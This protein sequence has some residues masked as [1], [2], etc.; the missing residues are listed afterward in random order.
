[1]ADAFLVGERPIARRVD[2]SVVRVRPARPR[3][4]SGARRGYAP[5]AV[6][7]AAGRTPGARLGADLKNT[8][9]LVVDG[10]AFVSQHIG[11]LEHYT[12]LPR[13]RGDDRT[14]CWRCTRCGRDEL[15]VVHDAHPQY[16]STAFAGTLGDAERRRRAAP[17]RP[18]RLGAGR[19]RRVGPPRARREP[20][21]HRL[22]R[23][24]H[25]L[26]RRALRRA[27]CATAS[28]AWPTSAPAALAGGDAAAR[29]PVQAAAGFLDAARRAARPRPPRRSTFPARYRAVAP[30]ARERHAR[31]RDHLGGPPVRHR[32]GAAGLHPADHVRGPGRDVAR[33]ARS[34]GA[35]RRAVSLPVRRRLS[36]TCD[37]CCAPSSTDRLRGRDR[38]EIARAFHAGWPRGLCDAAAALCRTHGLDTVVASGGVFQNELLLD[39]S[40][41]LLERGGLDA[42]D[43]PRGPAQRRRHQPGTGRARRARTMHELS[44]ALSLVD[45]AQEEAGRQGGRVCAL[46]LRLGALAGVVPEALLASYEMAC[47]ET[48]LEGSRLVIEEVPVVVFCPRCQAQRPLEQRAVVLLPRVRHAHAAGR[49]RPGAG[50]GRPGDRAMSHEPRLVEVRKNIL[51]QNDL[52]AREL[53]QRFRDAGVF[54]VSLVSSPGAG[55][56]TL[57]ERTLTLLHA[58]TPRRRAGGRSGHRERRGPPGA[59]RRAGPADHH[60]HGLPPRG[61]DGADARW[62]AGRSTSSTSCSS[63]TSATWCARRRTTWARACASS[64]CPSPRARTS[65][66]STP[67]S[68]TP[69]TSRSSPRSTW[70][71][72]VGFDWDRGAGQHPGRAAWHADARRLGEDRR[73]DDRAPG[74]ARGGPCCAAAA[75]G[76]GRS[77]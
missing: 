61:R 21:R 41:L 58:A 37:R 56:T 70:P 63:R 50:A 14:T 36:S 17:S 25:D 42:L 31:V 73:G 7:A 2:D 64:C 72:P 18:R 53:R 5:G 12:A 60:R 74:A 34:Q 68:S 28:S 15:L 62:R 59:Q 11:D 40:P 66:S 22:R 57:L 47:A 43:Q 4:S 3:R 33:A 10:Q 16:R 54:V 35:S 32:G 1:M 27:A 75:R 44:I 13:V 8:I 29:H 9:T 24:R 26:G 30:A 77:P 6:A 19:A 51:K 55:K 65:R 52:V 48:P 71:R 67:R 39:D 46:H 38:G 45:L 23:R 76:R 69:P 49:A 20:R